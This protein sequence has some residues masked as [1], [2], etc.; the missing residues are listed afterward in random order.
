M[1]IILT[2]QP[3]FYKINLYNKLAEKTD[4][5]VVFSN[6]NNNTRNRDFINGEMFFPHKFLSGSI[7]KKMLQFTYIVFSQKYDEVIL[8]EWELITP[9]IVA[10]VSPK[11]KNS[12]VVESSIIESSTTGVKGLLKRIFFSRISKAY[13]SGKSQAR[14]TRQLGMNGSNIITKGVGVFNYINQPP[15]VERKRVVN[16]VFVGRLIWQKNIEFLIRQF[17][18]HP[19]LLLHI[20]GSGVLESD[21]KSIA[22]TNIRFVGYVNNTELPD[23]YQKADVFVL[24]S[25]KEPWGLVVEEAL[26]NGTPVM[27]SENVGCAEEIVSDSNGVVFKLTDEDFEEKLKA[28]CNVEK[29]NQMRFNISKMDFEKIEAEQ[30]NCYL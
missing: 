15:Y 11:R 13:A 17:N 2:Y 7:F 22:N 3:A 1:K 30:I 19:E 26:N 4:I 6:V 10:F 20:I 16:F 14:L 23:Y 18:R 28:I 21:L 27:V 12:A 9:W 24:P 25:V 8:T 5:L 29:Y